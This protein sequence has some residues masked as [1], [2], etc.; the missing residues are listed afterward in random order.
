MA[1]VGPDPQDVPETALALRRRPNDG[2]QA[3]GVASSASGIELDWPSLGGLSHHCGRCIPCNFIA[4]KRGCK[5]G[6]SCVFCHFEHPTISRS[7][8]KKILDL[9]WKKMHAT[10]AAMATD[11]VAD[12]MFCGV[13]ISL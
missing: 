6:R 4:T 3:T 9:H 10:R 11:P 8:A 12:P 5:L 13:R 2:T 1:F 7:S